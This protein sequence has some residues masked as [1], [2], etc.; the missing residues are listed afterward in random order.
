VFE[1]SNSPCGGPRTRTEQDV[2]TVLPPAGTD[3]GIDAVLRIKPPAAG[4]PVTNP[5]VELGGTEGLRFRTIDPAA[6]ATRRWEL[7]PDSPDCSDQGESPLSL[8]SARWVGG[9]PTLPALLDFANSVQRTPVSQ[10]PVYGQPRCAAGRCVVRVSG[11]EG[12]DDTYN[13]IHI[14]GSQRQRITWWYDIET[15]FTGC[16]NG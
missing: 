6:R 15:C 2:D 3:N 8:H 16:T 4:R 11:V 14:R 12:Y 10:A 7:T 1:Y 9:D 13:S 5:Q